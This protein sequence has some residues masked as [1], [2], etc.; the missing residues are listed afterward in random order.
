M[1]ATSLDPQEL[2]AM[3]Q[4]RAAFSSFLTLHFNILPDEEFVEKMRHSD[5]ISMLEALAKDPTAQGDL[6]R[7][8]AM[9]YEFLEATRG[10]QPA[11]LSE[12]LGVDRTRLYRGISPS[13]GPPPPYEM[14]WSQT[15]NDLRLLQ[16]L[17]RTY[18][19][20]D[21]QP[22]TEIVD[23]MDYLGLELE[24]LHAL[25]TREAEAWGACE[26][27]KANDLFQAQKQFFNEHLQPWIPFFVE[28]ALEQAKTDFYRGHLIMLRGFICDQKALF[29]E[30]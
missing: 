4:A 17:A 18:R 3:A 13:Y 22:S 19:E 16:T 21:L 14:V 15:W 26:T 8:A 27:G 28:K 10:D 12:K 5:V 7:G 6:S 24:F 1:N 23:R 11:Q 20:N 2:S 29:P 25:S 30:Q 9:M